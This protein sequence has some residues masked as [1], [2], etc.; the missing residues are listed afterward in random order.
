MNIL[1]TGGAGFI[2]SH[3]CKALANQ[4]HVPI[5]YDNLSRGHRAAVKFGPLEVGDTA[6]KARVPPKVFVMARNSTSFSG[7]ASGLTVITG[8][9][10]VS[11]SH[12][13]KVA[14]PARRR[15][16]IGRR[17]RGAE[18]RG[19]NRCMSTTSGTPHPP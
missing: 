9:P 17:M 8:G 18:V 7:G 15:K 4:G 11:F 5:T 10:I 3:A 6:D 19:T 12:R 16:R 1:V 2:G 14:R 13:E